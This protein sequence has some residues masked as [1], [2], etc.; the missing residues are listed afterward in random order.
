MPVTETGKMGG[1]LLG[2]VTTRDID[3][4]DVTAYTLFFPY[5]FPDSHTSPYPLHP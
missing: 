1:K 5:P 4:I 3:F 2:I